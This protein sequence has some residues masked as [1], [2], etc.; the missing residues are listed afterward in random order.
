MTEHRVTWLEV[1]L[2]I[3]LISAVFLG[4]LKHLP[5][6]NKQKLKEYQKLI[7]NWQITNYQYGALLDDNREAFVYLDPPYDIKDNLYGKKGDMHKGFDH[8]TFATV[9]DNYVCRQMVSYN[10]NQMVRDR[11]K[12]WVASEYDLTYTMRSVGD[13]MKDQHERKELILMNYD[14]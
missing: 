6:V 5:S 11:F 12:G 10:S 14:V 1:L 2:S 8:D 7:E 13:Y 9:C 3:L 4:L